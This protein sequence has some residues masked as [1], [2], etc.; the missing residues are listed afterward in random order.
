MVSQT[1]PIFGDLDNS[2]EDWSDISQTVPHRD[3]SG[4][5]LMVRLGDEFREDVQCPSHH[6]MSGFMLL[7]PP[8]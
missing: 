6:V 3:L 5:F 2:P 1:S 8:M 7:P 4:V